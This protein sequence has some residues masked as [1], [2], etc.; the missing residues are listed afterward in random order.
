MA[1]NTKYVMERV[2][3]GGI[4]SG[5]A[6]AEGLVCKF[7]GPGTVFIQTRNAVGFSFKIR[8]RCGD[9]LLSILYRKP[10][11]DTCPATRPQLRCLFFVS[12]AIILVV[13]V[14]WLFLMNIVCIIL[15]GGRCLAVPGNLRGTPWI[16][17]PHFC[18]FNMMPQRLPLLIWKLC[19]I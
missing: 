16:S 15:A 17:F 1:W 2:A 4:I 14:S 18:L 12:K 19:P 3:S 7:T 8:R 11:P 6:S 10:L 9:P 5:F 13:F